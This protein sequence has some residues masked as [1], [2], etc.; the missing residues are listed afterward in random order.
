MSEPDLKFAANLRWLFPDLPL[1]RSIPAAAE[2]GFRGVEIPAPY[3]HPPQ[4][5]RRLL[6]DAGVA[7]V[8]LN[9]PQGPAGS[10]TANGAACLPGYGSQFRSGVERGLEY[11]EALGSPRLHVVAGRRPTEVSRER[12]FAQY[13]HNIGW[14]AERARATGVRLVVEMQ[15]Q[16]D[17]PGF[18]V[19]SQAAAAAVAE[20]VGEPVRLLFDVYHTQ[21]TEG[22]VVR[23]F[24]AVLPLVEHIQIGDAP[25]RSE[26]GTGELSW[27]FVFGHIRRSGYTGWL[28]CE[29]RPDQSAAG[30]LTRLSELI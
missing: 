16:R 20:A 3:E 15:N 6:D 12:A 7:A 14:A 4:Q 13:V 30:V 1:D 23:T 22:D 19:E 21:V 9:T 2:E 26:P 25:T 5:V 8:L 11:A 17:V 10:P 27:S 24:D 29:F 18:V 28:G